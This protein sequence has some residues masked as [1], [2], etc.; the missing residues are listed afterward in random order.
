MLVK[1]IGSLLILISGSSLG[2]L[3]GFHYLKR[4]KELKELQVAINIFDTEIS[5]GRTL[6]PEAL[7]VVSESTHGSISNIYMQLATGLKKDRDKRFRDIFK[8]ILSRYEEEVSLTPADIKILIEWSQ[9]IGVTSLEGQR[10]ANKMA[11]KRLEQVEKRAQ[12]L[13]DKRV[14]LSRYAG[15]LLSLLVIIAL[16]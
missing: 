5:Y 10:K 14:K 16:Y 8:E 6:L 15:V 13:A 12:D 9:Q 7:E 2:W 3:I 11:I 1:L 4:I